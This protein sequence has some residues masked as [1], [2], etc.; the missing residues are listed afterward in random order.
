[1]GHQRLLWRAATK[2]R[3]GQLASIQDSKSA[4]WQ[5]ARQRFYALYWS[6]LSL[7]ED[8]AVKNRMVRLE[9]I[10]ANYSDDG[11]K[12]GELQARVYCLAVALKASIAAGWQLDSGKTSESRTGNDADARYCD[13]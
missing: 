12:R 3:A 13:E 8:D 2:P 7:V 4:D 5:I 9:R 11:S 6:Q 1:M 10:L